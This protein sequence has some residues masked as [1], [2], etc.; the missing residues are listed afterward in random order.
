MLISCFIFK[1]SKKWVRGEE[2]RG[3]HEDLTVECFSF[4]FPIILAI[5]TC[6][7]NSTGTESVRESE[8]KRVRDMQRLQTRLRQKLRKVEKAEACRVKHYKQ[9]KPDQ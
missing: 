4:R 8:R 5:K 7:N 2:G 6:F 1:Q 9:V 3:K